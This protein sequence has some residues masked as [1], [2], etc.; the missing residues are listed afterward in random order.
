MELLR[1]CSF[2]S[3]CTKIESNLIEADKSFECALCFGLCDEAFH[4]EFITQLSNGGGGGGGGGDSY[5]LA[6]NL[7][8]SIHLRE[9]LIKTLYGSD[10]LLYNVKDQVSYLLLRR[11]EMV[12]F[13]RH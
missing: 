1:L 12:T 2:C 3:K 5:I 8:T 4:A 10:C 13:Y 7:P 6:L 11:I 9:A